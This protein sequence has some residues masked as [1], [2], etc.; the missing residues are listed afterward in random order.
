MLT[1]LLFDGARRRL[2]DEP[3]WLGRSDWSLRDAATAEEVLRAAADSPPVLV[4]VDLESGPERALEAVRALR[5]APSG[6]E[7]PLL[8][9]APPH[10]TNEALTAGAGRVFTSEA[11]AAA[12]LAEI[13]RFLDLI[14]RAAPR[15]VVDAPAAFWRDGRPT[16]GRVTDLSTSGFF[17][18]TSEPPPVGARLEISFKLPPDRTGRVVTGEVIVV[19]RVDS[20][21]SGFGSRFFRLP[22]NAARLIGDFLA[23]RVRRGRFEAY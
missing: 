6:G 5:A 10:R 17:A 23:P 21:E 16:E 15:V 3:T 19:R 14:E 12:I 4:I 13:G 11:P 7:I 22:Q 2:P 8:V 20:P 9:L 18:A 1:I